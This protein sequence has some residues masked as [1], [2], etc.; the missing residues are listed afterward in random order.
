MWT[1]SKDGA[2]RQF[3]VRAS[4]GRKKGRVR[5]WRKLSEVY[6]QALS[7]GQN[8]LIGKFKVA[9]GDVIGIGGRV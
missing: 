6:N 5:G 2:M 3:R 7:G 1:R 4:I 9:A 8:E